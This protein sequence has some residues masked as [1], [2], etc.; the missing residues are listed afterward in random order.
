MTEEL[1][2]H[3]STATRQS[4]LHNML[5]AEAAAEQTN[6]EAHGVFCTNS[7]SGRAGSLDSIVTLSF[8]DSD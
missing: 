4:T 3:S 8:S 5:E 7:R 2:S 1:T 6:D